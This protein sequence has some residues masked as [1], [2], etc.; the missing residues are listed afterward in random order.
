MAVVTACSLT[1]PWPDPL[2]GSKPLSFGE[3][4]QDRFPMGSGETALVREL[5]SEG[6]EPAEPEGDRSRTAKLTRSPG[7]GCATTWIVP[8]RAVADRITSIEGN[9]PS[10]CF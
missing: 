9:E 6:F 8:W 1:P 7:F 2:E 3:W 4:V 10:A 5:S